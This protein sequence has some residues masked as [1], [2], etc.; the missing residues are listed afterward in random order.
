MTKFL[1]LSIIL[2]AGALSF[3][4][5]GGAPANN[6]N[7]NKNAAVN[8]VGSGPIKLDPAN[9][10]EGINPQPVQPSAN[11][12][13]GIPATNTVLPKGGTPTPGIPSPEELKR[14]IKPGVT[15]TPGIPSPAEMKKAMQGKPATSMPPPDASTDTPM[16]KSSNKLPRKPQ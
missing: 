9:M 2:A 8:G 13:P 6:A 1:S 5:G 3:G 12:T 11:T 15:P 4:C 16:M 10:P 7:A 14:G